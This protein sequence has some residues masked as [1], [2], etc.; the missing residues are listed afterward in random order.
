MTARNE[1]KEH[2]R[3][4]ILETA[5]DLFVKKGYS[6][7][8]ITDIARAAGMSTGLLFHYFDSK[9]ALYRELIALG[10]D[11]MSSPQ[12]IAGGSPDALGFFTGFLDS[13]FEYSQK[14]PFVSKMFVLMSQARR[15]SGTPPE[16]RELSMSVD[17][18]GLSAEMIRRGQAEGVFREGDPVALS[19]AFWCC[20]RGIMELA[21]L[22]PDMPMP[23]PEW[24]IDIIKK[25]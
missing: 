22:T 7:T 6:E 23:E 25:K 24:I 10:A 19:A 21:S 12:R 9:E 1:Q 11:G 3:Q 15:S 18:I 8:K 5:L 13:L 17:Q 2:R 16:I 20:V 14:Q 4:M